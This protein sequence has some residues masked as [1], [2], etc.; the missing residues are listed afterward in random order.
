MYLIPF[1]LYYSIWSHIFID[2]RPDDLFSFDPD[3]ELT[4]PAT[5]D[6][7]SSSSQILNDPSSNDVSLTDLSLTLAAFTNDDDTEP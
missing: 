1:V 5:N 6:V 3:D 7:D 4:I 2:A